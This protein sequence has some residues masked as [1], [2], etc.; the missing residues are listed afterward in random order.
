M[1][2]HVRNPTPASKMSKLDATATKW[3]PCSAPP[4]RRLTSLPARND[5]TSTYRQSPVP[6]TI[7]LTWGAGREVGQA[8]R[9]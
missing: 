4:P 1:L 7:T 5:V 2:G 9:E 8:S 6:L 3:R